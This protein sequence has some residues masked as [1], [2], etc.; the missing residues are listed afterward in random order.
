M[1]S[2]ATQTFAFYPCFFF[3]DVS[4]QDLWPPEGLR[5][6]PG[7]IPIN[8]IESWCMS[9]RK[10]SVGQFAGRWR[11]T[12]WQAKLNLHPYLYACLHSPPMP[13]AGG[14][15]NLS[16][17]SGYYSELV[18]HVWYTGMHLSLIWC[19]Y[20]GFDRRSEESTKI[21]WFQMSLRESSNS[22]EYE[23]CKVTAS[24]SLCGL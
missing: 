11:A 2:I 1:L 16:P 8:V 22:T 10:R 17:S 3:S 4:L 23:T 24:P 13:R 20:T 7:D 18:R 12:R 21:M 19:V 14:R 5:G 15:Q 6:S 9:K